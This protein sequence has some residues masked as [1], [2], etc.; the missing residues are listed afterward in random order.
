[1]I[2]ATG[3]TKVYKTGKSEVRAVDGADLDVNPREFILILGRS[4]SGKSTLLGMLAGLIRPSSGTVRF[5][6]RDIGSLPDPAISELRA[7]EIGFV[8]Q[9]SGLIP[10]VTVLDNVLLPTLFIPARPEARSY[11]LDLLE[12]MDLAD[13]AGAYPRTLSSGEMKRVAIARALI[14]G[15]SLLIADEPTGDLDAY[16]EYEIMDLFR[17]L[18]NEGMTIVMVT[19]NPDLEQYATRIFGMDRGRLVERSHVEHAGQGVMETGL[20]RYRMP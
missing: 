4:G 17:Q 14:N 12:R 8:F 5:K 9:F 16:T 7:R 20:L 11:A 18:N 1:M 3:L 19:H 2:Q 6:G 15:P 10:T 13:R